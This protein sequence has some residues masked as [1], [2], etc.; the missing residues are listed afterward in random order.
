MRKCHCYH[1]FLSC[2]SLSPGSLVI[3]MPLQPPQEQD[4][5]I[6]MPRT[7]PNP[8]SD[9][10]PMI[11]SCIWK[12][13]LV[14]LIIRASFYFLRTFLLPLLSSRNVGRNHLLLKVRCYGRLLNGKLWKA[15]QC[16]LLWERK[17]WK[18]KAEAADSGVNL[19][20]LLPFL[21]ITWVRQQFLCVQRRKNFNSGKKKTF[22]DP[23]LGR[24]NSGKQVLG[25]TFRSLP[26]GLRTWHRKWWLGLKAPCTKRWQGQGCTLQP[27]WPLR[28]T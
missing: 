23:S 19:P 15:K 16:L 20:L 6:S 9:S 18:S 24:K 7:T 13:P 14:N 4:F 10:V 3:P 8:C 22:T 27:L 21:S 25:N 2:F 17:G 12:Y 11:L 1:P 26:P 5:A 28:W